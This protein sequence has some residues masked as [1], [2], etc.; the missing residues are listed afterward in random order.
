MRCMF[1]ILAVMAVGYSSIANAACRQDRAIYT[2]PNSGSQLVF[3]DDFGSFVATN[4]FRMNVP[5]GPAFD[6]LVMWNNGV[7]RAN[8]M[9]QLNCPDGDIPGDELDACTK[10][11]GVVYAMTSDGEIDLIGQDDAAQ[12]LILPD[13]SR[14]L[15][16]EMID[17]ERGRLPAFDVFELTE[18][19]QP[20]E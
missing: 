12:K 2:E 3:R 15:Y 8:G 4:S 16:Y 5:E 20:G 6:G 19:Q 18:C 14:T 17:A 9:L 11:E 10:W 7:A 13:V 1:A